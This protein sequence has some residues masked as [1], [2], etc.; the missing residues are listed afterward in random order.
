[1]IEAVVLAAGFSTRMG[2]PKPL[3]EIGGEPA[4]SRILG[5]LREAGL[6]H[7]IVVLGSAADD[8]REG[9]D[10]RGCCVVVNPSPERGLS[11]SL[12]LGMEAAAPR[13]RGVIVLL[14]DM[15]AI[16]PD[17]I[18]AVVEEARSGAQLIVPRFH[19]Q[20]GFPV[21]IASHLFSRLEK[22]MAGD[23]GARTFLASH[24]GLLTAIEV[25][26]PGCVLDF[27]RPEDL[28]RFERSAPCATSA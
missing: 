7:P 18:R 14:G 3:V 9:I 22:T 12:R 17:T 5:S 26:D 2:R 4:L 16:R 20:R 15:P 1:M 13:S 8:V 27:D 24:S 23:S 25:P 6:A 28:R 21:F 19:G 10:L 11:S